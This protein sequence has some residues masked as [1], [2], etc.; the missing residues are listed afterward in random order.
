MAGDVRAA[1]V[2]VAGDAAAAAVVAAAV[3]AD[4]G[5]PFFPASRGATPTLLCQPLG[6]EVMASE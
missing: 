1:A 5:N 4:A 2:V 6:R 3:D